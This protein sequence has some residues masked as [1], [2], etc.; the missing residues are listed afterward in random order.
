MLPVSKQMRGQKP[1]YCDV[2]GAPV[3][4]NGAYTRGDGIAVG[5][6]LR[7]APKSPHQDWCKYNA[8]R[9]IEILCGLGT[10]IEECDRPLVKLTEHRF[11]L[12][13]A[14]PRDAQALLNEH[15]PTQRNADEFKLRVARIWSGAAL[16]PYC[17]SATGIAR[18]AAALDGRSSLAKFVVV[19]NRGRSIPWSNFF[20]GENQ[21]DRLW[22]YLASDSYK[23]SKHPLAVLVHS[24]QIESDP[25]GAPR[26]IR[27]RGE[28]VGVEGKKEF[29]MPR[30]V[31]SAEILNSFQPEEDYVVFGWWWAQGERKGNDSNAILYKNIAI[32]IYQPAQFAERRI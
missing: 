14:L 23:L 29:L 2:C 28:R 25:D 1:L 7:L 8:L 26:A 15:P 19:K 4:Y 12:R 27:C 22:N 32:N 5:E 10:A 17:R 11:E 30:L 13:L 16:A 31:A 21:G 9:Q 20:F 18:I 3:I 6:Y 24:R